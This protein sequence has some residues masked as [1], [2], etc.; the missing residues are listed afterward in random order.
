MSWNQL[1]INQL[2]SQYTSRMPRR[3][4]AYTA[5][6]QEKYNLPVY[7]VLV[8]IF[9]HEE[10]VTISMRY[11]SNFMGLIARQDYRV[12]NLWEVDVE[13]HFSHR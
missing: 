3:I 11:E 6:A 10:I 1:N 12:I 4:R 13:L 5:L 7:P 8:N 9:Q 2:Q